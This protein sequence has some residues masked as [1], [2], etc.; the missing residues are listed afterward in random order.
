MCTMWIDG[1]NG[2]ARHLLRQVNFVVV[3]RAPIGDLRHLARGRGWGSLRFLS[4]DRST[5]KSDLHFEDSGGR[6]VPGLSVFVR[7]DD[8][9]PRHFYSACAIMKEEEYRGLDLYTPV[10]NLLDLLPQGRGEWMPSV[11]Y[12]D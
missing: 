12:A 5:F 4:S 1:F 10:W 6:Q 7:G 2:V 8:G 11:E 3:A 9:S